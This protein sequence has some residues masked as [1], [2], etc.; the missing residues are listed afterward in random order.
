MSNKTTLISDLKTLNQIAQTL[1]RAVDVRTALQSSLEQLVQLMGLETGWIFIH[2]PAALER[3]A[4]RGFNWR[5]IFNCHLRW[6][7]RAKML[8]IKTARAKT[9]VI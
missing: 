7:Y 4:G 8:G 6:I 2:E 5:L 9:P 3:W 1:N